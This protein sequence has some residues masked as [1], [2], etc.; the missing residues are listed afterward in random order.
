ML[1]E[2]LVTDL[3]VIDRLALLP[4][5]AMTALTGETGAGKTL[6]VEAIDLL[7]GGKADGSMVRAGADEAVVEGRFVVGTGR[8]CEEVI[9]RRVVPREG[10]SRAYVDGGLA[11]AANLSEVG[12][13][14]VDL[15]GQHD[16]QSLL[17]PSS[18]RRALDRYA[19]IDLEP[20]R[21]L[22][23]ELHDVD[24]RLAAL[25]GD[26]RERAREVDL[27]RF[28]ANELAAAR[29]DD[30]L[31]DERLEVEE[32][33]LGDAL[34]HR[35]AALVATGALTSD[36][37]AGELLAL[38]IAALDERAPFAEPVGR[39]RA[40]A[41]ELTDVG[42]EVR[43]M[44]EAIED[45]EERLAEVRARRKLLHD[46]GR[47]YGDTVDEMLKYQAEVDVRLAELSTRDELAAALDVERE[48]LVVRI[49]AAEAEIGAARREAAPRLAAETQVHLRQLAMP[50]A[51]LEVWVGEV[52]PG[53][54]VVFALAANPGSPPLPLAKVA[55]GGE[56]ARTM[57][58]LRLVLTE[59][60]DTLIFDEVDA[61]VGGEA[62][63]AVGKALA[64][65]G[66][67]HQVLVVTHLAQVAAFAQIQIQVAKHQARSKTSTSAT[68]L[69][70]D[71]RV[72]E[73]ARMLSGSPDSDAA[74]THAAELL[75]DA[76][77]P[78]RRR[79]RRAKAAS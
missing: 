68:V 72:V 33:R 19:G 23:S 13:R 52:D 8:E 70:G 42:S 38:A 5:E 43:A 76:T 47:K 29:L 14:L 15:H 78:P 58:A 1:V 77:A 10:R 48:A 4:G 2:L 31:E 75:G 67:R 64:A 74:R 27:L 69:D 12:R 65:L 3:G 66:A 37:G 28:Q 20:L 71:E 63:T 62:A 36:G 11:S 53:D 9:L 39:L 25:G 45:D 21:A 22:R 46:L 32:D 57:L 59:A 7:M 34:A 60:P 16:H 40:L 26:E 41:A 73:V 51:R 49:R 17:S 56:L 61:G 35:E 24:E 44:G 30:P 79:S 6:I 50:K 54:E 18:Q 55:S